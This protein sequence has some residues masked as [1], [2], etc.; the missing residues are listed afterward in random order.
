M[1]SSLYHLAIS[2]YTN[3]GIWVPSH[4]TV[5]LHPLY[6]W[7]QGK[8]CYKPLIRKCPNNFLVE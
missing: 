5:A 4:F 3:K 7:G 8:V 6:I 2:L 1:L